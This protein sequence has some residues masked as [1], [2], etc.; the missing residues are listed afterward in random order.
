MNLDAV[1]A[2][3]VSHLNVSRAFIDESQQPIAHALVRGLDVHWL[4]APHRL[5][6]SAFPNAMRKGRGTPARAPQ[7][8]IVLV[9]LE[10]LPVALVLIPKTGWEK[11]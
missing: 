2:G 11:G 9:S 3:K 6:S 4:V 5:G 7:S 1:T 10:F 8:D